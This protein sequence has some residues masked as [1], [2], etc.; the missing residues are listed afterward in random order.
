MHGCLY[1]RVSLIFNQQRDGLHVFSV[2]IEMAGLVFSKGIQAQQRAFGLCLHLLLFIDLT[3]FKRAGQGK[4]LRAGLLRV[5]GGRCYSPAYRSRMQL[6]HRTKPD[7]DNSFCRQFAKGV[8][9]I[10]FPN[11]AFELSVRIDFLKQPFQQTIY[12]LCH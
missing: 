3:I 12:L 9:G 2:P 10:Q 6:I 11:F 4:R 7:H 5:T 8:D 1:S